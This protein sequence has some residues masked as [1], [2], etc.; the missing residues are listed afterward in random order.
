MNVYASD[1]SIGNLNARERGIK[2]NPGLVRASVFHCTTVLAVLLLVTASL[3]AAGQP[4]AP[5]GAGQQD[6]DSGRSAAICEPSTQ[7]SPYIPV[8]SWIYA[9][10]LRLYSMGYIDQVYRER[11]VKPILFRS[12]PCRILEE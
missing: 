2:V 6:R 8:D 3:Y 12:L 1:F 7:G 5:G 9:A 11:Y 10:V 4:A